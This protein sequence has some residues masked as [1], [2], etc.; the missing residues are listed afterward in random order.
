MIKLK[1]NIRNIKLFTCLKHVR[2]NKSIQ[3]KKSN[4]DEKSKEKEDLARKWVLT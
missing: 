2:I 1:T 4:Q 3:S